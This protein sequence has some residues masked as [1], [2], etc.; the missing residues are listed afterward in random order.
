MKT[1]EEILK[2]KIDYYGKTEAAYQ[3]A[4]EEFSNMNVTEQ[5][6]L[7]NVIQ[8]VAV[9]DSLPEIGDWVL[10]S[11]TEDDWT[12]LAEI[13]HNGEGKIVFYNREVEIYPTHWCKLPKPPCA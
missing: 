6:R 9:S 1:Y 7:H 13:K 4:A 10:C 12:D 5:L 3:F 8:W 11:N 2:A